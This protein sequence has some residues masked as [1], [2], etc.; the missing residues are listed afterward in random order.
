MYFRFSIQKTIQAVG[1]LLRLARGRM[2]RLRLLKLL[3]IADRESLREFHR[4]IIGSRTVA[5][6]NGPLHNEVTTS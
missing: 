2:G 4:P 1:V 6:K 5:M 3:Y